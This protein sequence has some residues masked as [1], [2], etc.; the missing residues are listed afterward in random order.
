MTS[1]LE[2][3]ES[4]RRERESA[5]QLIEAIRRDPKGVWDREVPER[6]FTPGAAQALTEAAHETA[7]RDL[8]LAMTFAQFAVL[9]ATQLDPASHPRPQ[10]SQIRATCFKNLASVHRLRSEHAQA[11]RALDAADRAALESAALGYDRAVLQL[12][13]ALV[14]IEEQNYERATPLLANAESTFREFDDAVRIGQVLHSRSMI[15][16]RTGQLETAESVTR[17]AL[18][19]AKAQGDLR[20]ATALLSNLGHTL[21]RLSKWD[22]AARALQE[23]LSLSKELEMPPERASVEWA[24]AELRLRRGD[25]KVAAAFGAVA[26]QFESLHMPDE[27]GLAMLDAAEAH[28]SEGDTDAA[29]LAVRAAITAFESAKLPKRL[30]GA[31]AYLGEIANARQLTPP[32]IR[33][34]REYIELRP[35]TLFAP[36]D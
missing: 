4:L 27:Q 32:S 20:G 10:V 18:S 23:A 6:A 17:E 8:V 36:R 34:V 12:A 28:L 19:L 31:L 15:A 21:I 3:A 9:I 1:I 25:L 29:Y 26:L 16:Y 30:A 5:A 22:A 14:Y 11:H 2:L 35:L 24:L 33:Q 13:R 7:A